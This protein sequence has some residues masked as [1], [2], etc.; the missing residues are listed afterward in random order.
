MLK[1][2]S[3]NMDF[4]EWFKNAGAWILPFLGVI[5]LAQRILGFTFEFGLSF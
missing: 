1:K 4:A 2:Y 5:F 3:D